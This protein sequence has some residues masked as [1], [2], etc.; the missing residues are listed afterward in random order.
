M[1]KRPNYYVVP[2]KERQEFYN[3]VRRANRGI[4]ANMAAVGIGG[5]QSKAAQRALLGDYADR[6]SWHTEKTTFSRSVKFESK[7]DYEKYKRHLSQ[8]G[9]KQPER[10]V[11][12]LKAGYE[13][14]IIKSLTTAAIDN[15]IPLE[16]GRLP[17]NV[18][19]KISDLTLEQMTHFFHND[20][21]V[22]D[23]EYLPYSEVDFNGV[24]SAGFVENVD[25]I[26]NSLKQI[27]PNANERKYAE[28]MASG[29]ESR[30]ALA[31]IFPK[32]TKGQI[33]YYDY[34]GNIP[35]T[36]KAPRKRRKKK[37]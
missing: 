16:N 19:S 1:V 21:P 8:W 30:D 36:Y 12:A 23:L 7:R 34:S 22:A 14:A 29:L 9:G 10:T 2:E 20:E 6:A 37:R 31:Q 32:A 13:R 35:E 24:D 26:I 4:A 27:Y 33:V 18:R 25:T 28:L 3:L 11:D 17:G 5:I 15:N